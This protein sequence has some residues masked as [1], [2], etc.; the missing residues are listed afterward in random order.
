M[1]KTRITIVA[2]SMLAAMATLAAAQE[3]FS[4]PVSK[5]LWD[6]VLPVAQGI[7]STLAVF[8]AIYAAW[9]RQSGD[10]EK[11]ETANK[12]FIGVMISLFVIWVGPM[13]IKWFIS[14]IRG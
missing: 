3:P 11:V 1:K 2:L 9:L 5:I 7:G 8:A 14:L 13:F 4:D 10:P 12:W 6:K